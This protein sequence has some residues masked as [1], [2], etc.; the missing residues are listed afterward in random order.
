MLTR[1][2]PGCLVR[3]FPLVKLAVGYGRGNNWVKRSVRFPALS[4]STNG[5]PS[6]TLQSTLSDHH[7]TKTRKSEV[8][9][10]TRANQRVRSTND[11]R[12]LS[13][14]PDSLD[15]LIAA[16]R[17]EHIPNLLREL[18]R[19]RTKSPVE[20]H[21]TAR[22]QRQRRAIKLFAA[23]PNTLVPSGDGAGAVSSIN[24]ILAPSG[25]R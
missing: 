2:V 25:R 8:S 23:L 22:Y 12:H 5:L 14:I 20:A 19:L 21:T 1:A 9:A 16:V 18:Q 6:E 11:S 4:I 13:V 7:L 24:S 17:A 15:G 3:P 10:K